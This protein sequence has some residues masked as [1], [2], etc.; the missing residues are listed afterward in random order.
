MGNDRWLFQKWQNNHTGSANLLN[1]QCETEP[2]GELHWTFP[3]VQPRVFPV[4]FVWQHACWSVIGHLLPQ[5]LCSLP[6]Y[7]SISAPQTVLSEHIQQPKGSDPER[8]GGEGGEGFAV[9]PKLFGMG[10]PTPSY[11]TKVSWFPYWDHTNQWKL[12][13]F[14]PFSRNSKKVW[15]VY[16][17]IYSICRQVT[18]VR[19]TDTFSS[20]HQSLVPYLFLLQGSL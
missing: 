20:N 19:L 13:P 8:R 5:G 1:L 11:L 16:T 15:C 2:P 17:C 9:S 7:S 6:T 12:Q 10:S 18:P 3:S 4:Y 14:P